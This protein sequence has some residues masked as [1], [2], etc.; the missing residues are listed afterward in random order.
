MYSKLISI[1][2]L[3]CPQC[4]KGNMLKGHPY[5]LKKFNQVHQHCP[6]CHLSLKIEPSF[7]YGSMYVSYGL[8]VGLSVATFLLLRILLGSLSLAQNFGAICFALVIAMPY[9]NAVSK[10]IWAS[11]FFPYKKEYASKK[12]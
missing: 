6:H 11:F 1:L 2:S 8:G 7:Y 9:L 10:V 3:K 5:A 12:E 4:R